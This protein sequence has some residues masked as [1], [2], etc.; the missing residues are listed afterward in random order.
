MLRTRLDQNAFNDD[1]PS[2]L[3]IFFSAMIP[4]EPSRSWCKTLPLNE[5]RTV[6]EAMGLWR[7]NGFVLASPRVAGLSARP[8]IRLRKT[9]VETH[10]SAAS[11]GQSGCSR[12]DACTAV[13][14]VRGAG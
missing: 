5:S 3:V 14:R 10:Q 2:L 6:C 8:G 11:T 1:E 9:H 12:F 4:L 7:F 13:Q